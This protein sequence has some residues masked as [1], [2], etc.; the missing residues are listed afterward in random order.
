MFNIKKLLFGKTVDQPGGKYFLDLVV[1]LPGPA[2][3]FTSVLYTLSMILT[4]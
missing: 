2:K 3:F 1:T 4:D